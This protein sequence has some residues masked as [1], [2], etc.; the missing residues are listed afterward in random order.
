MVD[1]QN[2]F[3]F[4][5]LRLRYLSADINRNFTIGFPGSACPV[6]DYGYLISAGNQKAADMFPSTTPPQNNT[7]LQIHIYF[8]LVLETIAYKIPN[9]LMPIFAVTIHTF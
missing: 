1:F 4:M 5:Q 7:E 6:A 9:K 8:M 3:L 2:V